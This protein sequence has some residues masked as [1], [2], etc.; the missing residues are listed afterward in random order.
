MLII[1]E[2]L[3]AERNVKLQ[4]PGKKNRSSAVAEIGVRLAT[5]DGPKSGGTA[6]PFSGG[7]ADTMSPGPRP[8]SLLIHPTV[9]PQY[10]NVTDKQDR[11]ERTDNGPI[12]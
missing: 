6:A 12:A 2:L 9:W 1:H 10:A 4:S 11:Q 7:E 3:G 5:I 8:T